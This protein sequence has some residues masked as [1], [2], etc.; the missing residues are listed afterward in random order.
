M[1]VEVTGTATANYAC[2]SSKMKAKFGGFYVAFLL[3]LFVVSFI[4]LP[5]TQAQPIYTNSNNEES[6]G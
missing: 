5:S 4:S 2:H 1:G 3:G 6:N